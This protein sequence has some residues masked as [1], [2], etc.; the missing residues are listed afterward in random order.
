MDNKP[1][2][3]RRLLGLWVPEEDHAA[4]KQEAENLG[5]DLSTLLRLR[6]FG[7]LKGMRVI[8]RPSA[9]VMLLGEVIGRLTAL[10][11]EVNKIGSNLNQIAKRL[12]MGS[13]DLFGLDSN[14]RLFEAIGQ[15]TLKVLNQV[16]AA[17]TGRK[18]FHNK[19]E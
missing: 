16:E 12:N 6:I 17:I 13:R 15:K 9:D 8:R 14:L 11:A 7:K 18:E 3:K 1:P 10:T 4:F 19:E 5:Y 2:P